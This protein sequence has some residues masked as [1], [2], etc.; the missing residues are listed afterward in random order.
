MPFVEVAGQADR[1]G[2]VGERQVA[3]VAEEPPADVQIEPAV[4]VEVDRLRA[5]DPV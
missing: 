3:V 1:V 2:D 4:A 5:F